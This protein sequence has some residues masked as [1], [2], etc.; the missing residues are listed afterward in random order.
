MK[1]ALRILA[2]AV[3]VAAIA[4]WAMAGAHWGLDQNQVP[5]KTLDEVTGIEGV[6]YEKRFVPG[7]EFMGKA[8]TGAFVLLIASFFFRK[9]RTGT[10][11]PSGL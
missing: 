6:T 3:V 7:A 8:F 4:Y 1:K 9:K 10:A 5:K 2:A 11:P